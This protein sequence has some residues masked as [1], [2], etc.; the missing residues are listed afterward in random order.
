MDLLFRLSKDRKDKDGFSSI[1]KTK[2]FFTNDLPRRDNNYF[3]H[4]RKISQ[5]NSGDTIYFSYDG[6]LV[7]KAIFEGEVKT[8]KERNKKFIQGHKVADIQLLNTSIKLNPEVIKGRGMRYIN[9]KEIRDEI[10]RVLNEIFEST[11]Y[12]DELENQTLSE[13]AKKQV[14]VNA[15]ERSLKARQ[16]CIK[17]YGTKC[18]ICGF[19]FEKKYGEIGRE[20]IHVHHIKPLSEINEEYKVNPIQDLRPVCPNCHAMIHKK[21]PAYSIEEIKEI[22]KNV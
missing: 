8:D 20:F 11:I 14:I 9:T 16:E 22:V 4:T 1:G 21:K 10:Q 17:H 13:G 6:Y 5:M 3:F 2:L 19:D 12:P 18:F 7:A 15:Y